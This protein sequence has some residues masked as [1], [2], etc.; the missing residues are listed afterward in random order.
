MKIPLRTCNGLACL[1]FVVI[2][3]SGARAT[4]TSAVDGKA[5]LEKHC[6]RCHSI[7]ATGES[8]LPKAP[9]LWQI[10]LSY[11]IEQLEGGSGRGWPPPHCPV[12][13]V[14]TQ[15]PCEFV[16]LAVIW[17]LDTSESVPHYPGSIRG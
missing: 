2:G 13:W 1:V 7:T 14:R 8:P 10:Y 4:D 6:G 12:G 5:I 11:P 16:D 9:P 3:T 15:L 17:S